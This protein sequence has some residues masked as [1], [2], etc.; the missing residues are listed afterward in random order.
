[1]TSRCSIAQ[2]A[3]WF[4]ATGTTGPGFGLLTTE[5]DRLPFRSLPSFGSAIE[6]S[7]E[8]NWTFLAN[9]IDMYMRFRSQGCMP[10]SGGSEISQKWYSAAH[11][12]VFR[13]LEGECAPLVGTGVVALEEMVSGG[14]RER[15]CAAVYAELAVDVARMDFDRADRKH[16][17]PGNL[18]VGKPFGNEPQHL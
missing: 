17:P 11:V 6:L 18:A 16:E 1:M 7:S 14:L 4:E 15:L 8:P 10:A 12:V 9:K 2:P 3:N 13:S 5:I